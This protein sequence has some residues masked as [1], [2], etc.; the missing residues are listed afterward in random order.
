MD[1][2]SFPFFLILCVP[3]WLGWLAGSYVTR[4]YVASHSSSC[5]RNKK[6]KKKEKKRKAIH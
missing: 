1:C 5:T 2:T 6:K 3:G 4:N